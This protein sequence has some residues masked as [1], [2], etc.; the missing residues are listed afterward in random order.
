MPVMTAD[1]SA[2]MVVAAKVRGDAAEP[3]ATLEAWLAEGVG[4][5]WRGERTTEP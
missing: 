2:D 1:V 3:F 4:N 5:Q